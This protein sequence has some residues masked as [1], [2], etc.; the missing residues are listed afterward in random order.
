MKEAILEDNDSEK[1]DKFWNYFEK[2]WMSSQKMIDSWNISN[3]K[4]NK[5]V[6]KRTN[7]GLERKEANKKESDYYETTDDII[8]DL[9]VGCVSDNSKKLYQSANVMKK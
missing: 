3:F 2:Y 7:N 6:L 4:G 9:R 1:M 5:N 8:K